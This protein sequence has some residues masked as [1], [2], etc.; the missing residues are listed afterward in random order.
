MQ[1]FSMQLTG[2]ANITPSATAELIEHDI[3]HD[4]ETNCFFPFL[5]S[6]PRSKRFKLPNRARSVI[7]A[8]PTTSQQS[9]KNTIPDSSLRP[10]NGRK[11]KEDEEESTSAGLSLRY[12]IFILDDQISA[13]CPAPWERQVF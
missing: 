2:R 4:A 1:D 13:F 8:A 3:V 10:P 5:R 7:P 11:Q 6:L 9:T 12:L